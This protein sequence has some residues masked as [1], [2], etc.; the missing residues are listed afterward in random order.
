VDDLAVGEASKYHSL[1]LSPGD[2]KVELV[3]YGYTPI[4]QTVA[5]TAKRTN[6]L[7]ITLQPSSDEPRQ[8]TI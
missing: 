5:I 2:H 1:K 8:C 3:N 7:E 4:T 6:K